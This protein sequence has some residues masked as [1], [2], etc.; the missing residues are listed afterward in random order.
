MSWLGYVSTFIAIAWLL[1][2]AGQAVLVLSYCRCLSR[3]DSQDDHDEAPYCP[4]A[5]VILCLRGA[6]P[7]LSRCLDGLAN[8]EYATYRLY[9]VVDDSQDPAISEFEAAKSEFATE[10]VL[11]SIP[12]ISKSR[13]LKCSA[14]L[15]AFEQ[16]KSDAFDPQV[17]ALVDADIE[18]DPYWLADLVTPLKDNSIGAASGN[19]WFDP[20][21]PTVGSNVRQIWNAAAVVQMYHYNIAWGGSLAFRSELIENKQ[22]VDPLKEGFCE[23]T[24][25]HGVLSKLGLKLLRVPNLIMNCH[26]AT[27]IWD[28][29][30]FINRQLFN[31][32]LY[33]QKWPFVAA[34]GI[35]GLLLNVMTALLVI[36]SLCVGSLYWF[37]PLAAWLFYQVCNLSLLA[38]ITSVNK[39][40]VDQRSHGPRPGKWSFTKY[41]LGVLATQVL[42]GIVVVRAMTQKEVTWRGIRYA[43]T[44]GTD[45][46]MLGYHPFSTSSSDHES[47][48]LSIE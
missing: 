5:A 3:D 23:D 38:A 19:R 9:V 32:R 8:Q 30:S 11:L 33:H 31:A 14:L 45:V 7:S 36:G 47:S 26:E 43:V 20:L 4:P 1:F 37:A 44:H 22:F 41:V 48:E 16:I 35:A 42:H 25:M 34:H 17:I 13:S 27:T 28:S 18:C 10:P 2:S 40:I 21:E 46:R 15:T 24:G 12:E 29:R 6:D 39:K